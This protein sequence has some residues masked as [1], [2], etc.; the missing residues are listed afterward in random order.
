MLERFSALH[1][2]L[3]HH[4]PRDLVI[5]VNLVILPPRGA[6]CRKMCVEDPFWNLAI[7]SEGYTPTFF[8]Y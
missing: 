5:Q 2:S 1:G 4:V 7:T 3:A 8:V 6:V